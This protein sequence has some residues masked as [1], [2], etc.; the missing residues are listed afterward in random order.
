[1][2]SVL[3]LEFGDIFRAYLHLCIC[4]LWICQISMWQVNLFTAANIPATT[5]ELLCI[6]FCLVGSYPVWFGCLFSRTSVTYTTEESLIW[7]GCSFGCGRWSVGRIYL[8]PIRYHS[9]EKK[10]NPKQRIGKEGMTRGGRYRPFVLMRVYITY[11]NFYSYMSGD[12][13]I[14]HTLEKITEV[15]KTQKSEDFFF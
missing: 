2:Q 6:Y 8:L 1:M 4:Q 10:K 3:W 11:V 12:L 15:K 9:R 5:S 7:I 14:F 13:F